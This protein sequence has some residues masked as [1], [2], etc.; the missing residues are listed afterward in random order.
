MRVASLLLL[1]CCALVA[2]PP[3]GIGADPVA[4]GP[5]ETPEQL[6]KD[7]EGARRRGQELA[8]ET[9]SSSGPDWTAIAGG[10]AAGVLGAVAIFGGP[11]GTLGLRAL[12]AF[13]PWIRRKLAEL[14]DARERVNDGAAAIVSTEQ[15]RYQLQALDRMLAE[16]PREVRDRLG[17]VVTQLTGGASSSIEGLFVNGIV[18]AQRDEGRQAS[19]AE[20]R[21]ELLDERETVGGR[22][23]GAAS[24]PMILSVAE[25]APAPTKA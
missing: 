20:W 23:A 14:E 21:R 10:V 9:A 22:L 15:G 16:A 19:I 11:W 24:P 6:L 25:P 3:P 1:A 8:G 7:P 18:A 17:Q 12:G 5:R 13:S 4:V 2:L